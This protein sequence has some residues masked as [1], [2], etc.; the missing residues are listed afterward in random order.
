MKLVIKNEVDSSTSTLEPAGLRLEA[1]G[2]SEKM[3]P[4]LWDRA[5]D[6]LKKTDGQLVEEYE[7]LLSTQLQTN[8]NLHD[9]TQED[10]IIAK[11]QINGTDPKIRLEQL[12]SITS[13][14]L[15]QLEVGKTKYNVFGR[16][17]IPRNQLARSMRFI[18]NIR[19]IIDEAVR[20][21]PYASLAW[22][23]VSIILPTFLDTATAEEACHK[24]FLY[25][26]SRI[27]YYNKL[28][29]LLLSSSDRMQASG[30]SAV[31]EDRLTA[32]Y[33]QI[34]RY[35]MK[36]VRRV[37]LTRLARLKEDITGHEDW[38]GMIAEI[39]ESE[40][41]L[42][43]D[44]KQANDSAIGREL[45]QLSNNA[46][47]FFTEITSML[48]PSIKDNRST[49]ASNVRNDGSSGHFTTTGG[50][51]NII[52]VNGTLLCEVTSGGTVNFH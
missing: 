2:Q 39:Q 31:L 38:E 13:S 5:Y 40:K 48:G 29:S 12:N 47:K 51:Q 43:N 28:E 27:Q 45:E 36:T 10:T 18:Q 11:N 6:D 9:N 25:L 41:I 17:F 49:P 52:I 22:A 15:Q 19:T 50:V 20:V 37:N 42:S 3:K 4:L 35:L 16:E 32:L 44:A 33:G 1:S 26:S 21:S 14:G 46:E 8:T 30:L 34:I 24:G 23:G 7:K